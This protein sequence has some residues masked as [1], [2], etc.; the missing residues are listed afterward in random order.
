MVKSLNEK[1]L[2]ALELKFGKANVQNEGA[3]DCE[4]FVRALHKFESCRL[5]QVY[6]E[7]LAPLRK[8][9]ETFLKNRYNSHS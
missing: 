3:Q 8:I 4:V 1:V 9:I 5:R 6:I 7:K 2:Q